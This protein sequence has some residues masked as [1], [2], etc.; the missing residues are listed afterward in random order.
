MAR[1]QVYDYAVTSAE[2]IT[3]SQS[4]LLA[5][6]THLAYKH[7]SGFTI[8]EALSRGTPDLRFPRRNGNNSAYKLRREYFLQ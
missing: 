8:L 5:W 7:K 6:G 4:T 3:A 1:N 2:V